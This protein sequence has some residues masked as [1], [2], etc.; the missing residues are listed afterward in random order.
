[1]EH[2]GQYLTV[3]NLLFYDTLVKSA[4]I[5]KILNHPEEEKQYRESAAKLKTAINKHLYDNILNAYRD[6][7]KSGLK[8]QGVSA[9][10][11]QVG[12][13]PESERNGV[14]TFVKSQRFGSSVVLAY[15]L[16]EM[17]YDNDE[18]A[19]AYNWSTAKI[20][21]AGDTWSSGDIPRPGK[22]GPDCSARLTSIRSRP[23]WDGSSSAA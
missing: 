5:A 9:L 11:L 23:T 6:C 1:V 13:V 7:S 12:V 2:S 14:M 4:N 20:C 15:N 22:A 10:A 3:E 16:F 8:H 17:L 19:F 21:R 18:G